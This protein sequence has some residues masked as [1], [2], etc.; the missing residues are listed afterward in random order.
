MKQLLLSLLCACLAL[1]AWAF[2]V[3]Q[4]MGALAQHKGGRARFVE[5]KYIALLDKPVVS[6]GELLYVAPDRLE[7]RT[8]QPKQ[9]LL[10]LDRDTLS[11]E[12]GKQKYTLRLSEQPEAQAFVESVRGTLAGNRAVLERNYALRITGN[13]ARWSLTLLP[14]DQKIATLVSRIT[15]FGS[16]GMVQSIEYLLADGDRS[17]MTIEPMDNP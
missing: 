11:I 4:L 9:E 7:K 14:S 15:F 1:P 3:G 10:V 8:L 17:V 12:R 13:E 16:K 6:S 2:D 5:K